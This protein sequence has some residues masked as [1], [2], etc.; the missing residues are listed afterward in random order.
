VVYIY[1]SHTNVNIRK[2]MS[3]FM[4]LALQPKNSRLFK[5]SVQQLRL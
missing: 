3:G 2:Y 4:F 1:N 5:Q